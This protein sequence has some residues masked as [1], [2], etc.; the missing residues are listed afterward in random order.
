MATAAEL[1][2]L[3]LKIEEAVRLHPRLLPVPGPLGEPEFRVSRLGLHNEYSGEASWEPLQSVEH[4]GLG[5]HVRAGDLGSGT[6]ARPLGSGHRV[7]HRLVS[8]ESNGERS[9]AE[10]CWTAICCCGWQES[11]STRSVAAGEYRHHRTQAGDPTLLVNI[12][13]EPAVPKT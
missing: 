9:L 2:P 4:H 6:Q 3:F 8:L 13:A 7:K 5:G 11:G 10:R 1:E 12:L